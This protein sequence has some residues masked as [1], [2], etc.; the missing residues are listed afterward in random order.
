MKWISSPWKLIFIPFWLPVWRICLLWVVSKTPFSQ[1]TSMFST[2]SNPWGRRKEESLGAGIRQVVG[3]RRRMCWR[4]ILSLCCITL[5]PIQE[6]K[7][8]LNIIKHEI[9]SLKCSCKWRLSHRLFSF[10]VHNS[11]SMLLCDTCMSHKI[12]PAAVC[13]VIFGMSTWQIFC[14]ASSAVRPLVQKRVFF[15]DN[16]YIMWI[17]ICYSFFWNRAKGSVYQMC[18]KFCRWV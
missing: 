5:L 7:I 9:P 4:Y 12:I 13:S 3:M 6:V 10:S 17:F 8:C 18:R 15:I 14:V 2:F 1:N 16:F 11:K